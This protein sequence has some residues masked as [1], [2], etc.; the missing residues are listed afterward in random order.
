MEEPGK[1]TVSLTKASQSPG[2]LYADFWQRL[3]SAVQ[4]ATADP[5]I[6]KV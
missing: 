3:S 4:R 2:E 1:R 6:R 5:D